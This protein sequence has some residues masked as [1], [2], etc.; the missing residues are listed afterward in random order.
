MTRLLLALLLLV[1]FIARAAEVKMAV[2]TDASSIDPHYH[3]FSP[4]TAVYRHIFDTLTRLGA[5]GR[6]TPG[7]A[8]SWA[9]VAEDIW[10]FK[11]RPNV[12]FHDGSPFSAEDVAFSV[13]RAPNV[14]NSPS[15]YLQYTKA[16]ARTEIVDPLTIRIHTKGPAPLLPG[17]L[18]SIAIVSKRSAEGK[19]TSDFNNGAATIGTGPYRFV[20]WVPANYLVLVRNDTYWGGAEPWERVTRRPIANDGARVATILSGDVD[21][22]EGVPAV[23]RARLLATPGLALHEIDS[24]RVIYLHMDSARDDSPGISDFKG[25]KI[26]R[27]PLKDIR[28]RRAISL[29]INRQGLADRLLSGQA[30]PAGQYLPPSVAGASPNLKPLPYDP[31]QS[32]ALLNEAGW[33]EGFSVVLAGSNDRYPSDAQVTQAVGQMLA[34]VGIKTDVRTMPSAILFSRGTKLEFSMI[35]S[36]WVGTGDPS[37]PLVALMATYN[38]ETGMGPSNRGRWSN[39]GFDAVLGLALRTLDDTKRNGLFAHAAEIAIEDMGVIPI[40]FTINTWASKKAFL[41]DARMDET[42]LAM[43]FRPAK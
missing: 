21:L 1:P 29:A 17:D 3:V 41:Y 14:P 4:N 43:G 26:A 25:D 39:P 24:T 28:V 33:G 32:H 10:E 37:S 7:L 15:S 13:A 38:P 31:I 23:D 30:H 8:L 35:L 11:L 16:V 22:I 20:E 6:L 9:A 2:R 40:Y 42:T 19:T 34:R 5:R 36:G 12:V 18:G 27:N